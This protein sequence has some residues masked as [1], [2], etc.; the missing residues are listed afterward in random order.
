MILVVE[1]PVSPAGYLDISDSTVQ[2]LLVVKQLLAGPNLY[3]LLST[4]LL[5]TGCGLGIALSE[6]E[7][8]VEVGDEPP[9]GL[10]LAEHNG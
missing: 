7:G 8:A 9:G 2:G 6:G 10:S 5:L 4:L 3:P 1:E